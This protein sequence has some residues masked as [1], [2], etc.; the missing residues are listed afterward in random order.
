MKS[1]KLFSSKYRSPAM[2]VWN[3]NKFVSKINSETSSRLYWGAHSDY[4]R[5]LIME[6]GN[7]PNSQYG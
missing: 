2:E 3:M 1:P 6:R 7:S 4:L 5:G